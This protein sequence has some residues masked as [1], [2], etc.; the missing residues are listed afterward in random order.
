[1]I[2]GNPNTE[3]EKLVQE[4]YQGLLAEEGYENIL[5]DHNVRLKGKS[6]CKHQI[7]VYWE[8]RI[9]GE[10]HRVAI[11]CKN[12]SNEIQIGKVRDFYGALNDIGGIKGIMVT[13][14]GYQSGAK[15]FAVH[16]GISLK[17][18]RF[19]EEKDWE[20]RIK[21]IED[22][23]I[24]T[25]KRIKKVDEVNLDAD[26]I[27]ENH[28]L[29]KGQQVQLTVLMKNGVF[30][31]TGIPIQLESSMF[32]SDKTECLYPFDD[33]YVDTVELGIVKVK[34]I[35]YVYD[36]VESTPIT[37]VVDGAEIVKAI[38]K[39]VKTGEIKFFNKDGG[40]K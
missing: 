23:L 31:K 9:G 26:W 5:V 10:I 13:K 29:E 33:A 38:L 27:R 6:G 3:Y 16:H 34:S 4:I 22:Q 1:M 19:P 17:E 8:V 40:I 21:R 7:D 39:D 36:I 28:C 37:I 32:P 20:E 18:I 2:E 12:Y 24:L 15:Q 11:E 35:K 25:A 14:V 30:D